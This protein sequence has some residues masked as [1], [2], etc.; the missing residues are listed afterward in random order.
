MRKKSNVVVIFSAEYD[1]STNEIMKWLRYYNQEFIRFNETENIKISTILQDR[2]N[3]KVNPLSDVKSI[4]FRRGKINFLFGVEFDKTAHI[5]DLK[6]YNYLKHES[7]FVEEILDFYFK[8]NFY[9]I[10]NQYLYQTNRLLNQV[11][12]N[13]F[14]ISTPKSLITNN[15]EELIL[16]YNECHKKIALKGIQE[17]FS[18]EDESHHYS[19]LTKLIENDFITNLGDTPPSLVS[20]E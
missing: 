15:K 14:G 3:I 1:Y 20:C 18:G 10:G 6:I 16:F 17:V 11:V 8:D 13:K 2:E 4:L 5:I 9:T 19:S 7:K 12:A